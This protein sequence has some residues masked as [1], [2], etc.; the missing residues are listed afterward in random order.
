MIWV[1]LSL[2]NNCHFA[3][4]FREEDEEE[5]DMKFEK[6]KKKQKFTLFLILGA[7]K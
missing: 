6:W 4:Q 2:A 5:K 3:S 7:V 1:T